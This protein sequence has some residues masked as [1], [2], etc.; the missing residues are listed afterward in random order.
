MIIQQKTLSK[1][2]EC[3]SS[4]VLA[5]ELNGRLNVLDGGLGKNAMTEIEN[6]P[7]PAPGPVQNI[8]DTA[9]K[10]PAEVQTTPRGPNSPVRRRRTRP[11][12][13]LHQA[14][15]ANPTPRHRCRHCA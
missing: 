13:T 4:T 15:R 9:L 12:P 7:G 1:Q 2:G 10:F 8:Y 6:V 11:A 5:N 14:Q 3:S